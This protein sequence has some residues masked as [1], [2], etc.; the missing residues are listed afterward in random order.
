MLR[1]EKLERKLD[2]PLEL[3][4]ARKVEHSTLADEHTS[5][6]TSKTPNTTLFIISLFSFKVVY[7]KP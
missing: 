4:R 2:V 7:P 1:K 6:N 3:A 5:V